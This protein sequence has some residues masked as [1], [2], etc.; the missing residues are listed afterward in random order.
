MREGARLIR[1]SANRNQPAAQYRLA[2]LYE[3]GTGVAQDPVTARELI[4]RAARGGNRIAM[5]DLGNYHAYGQGGLPVDINQGLEWFTRA[6]ERG[7]VD[8]QFNVAFLNEGKEGVP[9][10][11]ETALFWYYVAAR[12]GDQG[13]PGR[14]EELSAEIDAATRADIKARADQFKPKPVDEAANG[15]FRGVPWSKPAS[16]SIQANSGQAQSAQAKSA[17]ITKIRDAQTLL[18]ELGYQVGKPDGIAGSKT[19]D[20]IKS[21]EAVNGMPQTGEVTEDLI[22]RLEVASGA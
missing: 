16:P 4:E 17:E 18:T 22:Q 11:L 6:A 8:S 2:K 13:A 15:I 7:V 12:Q 20:A 5:H 21:F 9:R 3:T 1:L 10:N 19:R 14:I